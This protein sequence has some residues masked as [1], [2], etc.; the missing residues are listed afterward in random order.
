[1]SRAWKPP[2]TGARTE[3]SF[4]LRADVLEAVDAD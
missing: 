4:L 1:M 2:I 3:D